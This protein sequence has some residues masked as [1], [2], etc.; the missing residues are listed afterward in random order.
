MLDINLSSIVY[1]L[2]DVDVA[3]NMFVSQFPHQHMEGNEKKN[4]PHRIIVRIEMDSRNI[5]SG[6]FITNIW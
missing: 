4:L 6:V 3:T 5:L 2:C 1:Q